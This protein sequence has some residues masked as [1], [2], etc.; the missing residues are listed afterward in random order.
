MKYMRLA[1][2]LFNR[3]LM[4]SEAKLNVVQHYFTQHAGLTINGSAVPTVEAVEVTDRERLQAGYSVKNGIGMIG[5]YGPLM[6]RVLAAE[7]PSG[8]PT[9]YAEI[10]KAFDL[11]MADDEVMGIVLDVDSPGGEVSGVFD[12]GDHIYKSRAIKPITAVVNESAFSAAYL[13][14]SAAGKVIVPRTGGCG[15]IGVIATHTEFSR[16]EE[17][18][19]IT[20]THVYAGD[21]KADF[22][23]HQ[24]L[25]DEAAASLQ[26]MVNDNYKM[27]VETVARNRGIS[28]KE[29]IDTQAGIYE[30]QKAVTAKLADQVSPVDKAIAS[31]RKGKGTRLIAASAQS[32]ATRKENKKMPIEELREQNP[33]LVA[34]IENEARKGMIS[35][36]DADAAKASAVTAEVESIMALVTAS[37]GEDA[38]KKITMA[39]SKGLSAEDLAE[40]GI[41]LSVVAA[42]TSTEQ[43]MLNAITAA[44]SNGVQTGKGGQ[45]ETQAASI[46][47]AGIYASRQEQVASIGR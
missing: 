47:T 12:L 41:T 29:V 40:M 38:A 1:E 36:A 46:D 30:G 32:K 42:G 3:P 9:T 14:A 17:E 6:H 13:L 19:G 44:A 43:Q 8:G 21:R 15:S 16:W 10:R 33:D 7:F 28:K 25:T 23:P 24:P 31:A 37:V 26:E 22:S 2:R 18:T 5:I 20:V 34:Q 45:Q 4:I 39:H 11:A 27:F 35:Q